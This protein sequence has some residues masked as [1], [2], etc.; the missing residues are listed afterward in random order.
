M[1][2]HLAANRMLCYFRTSAGTLQWFPLIRA[3]SLYVEM[4]LNGDEDPRSCDAVSR[5]SQRLG[6]VKIHD[7]A[8]TFGSLKIGCSLATNSAIIQA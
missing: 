5:V 1:L 3:H 4:G 7:L 6:A 2:V 8:Q